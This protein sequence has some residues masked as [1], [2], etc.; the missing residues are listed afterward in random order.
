MLDG[1]LA[2]VRDEEVD[3]GVGVLLDLVVVGAA[4]LELVGVGAVVVWVT[5]LVG[6]GVE[7]TEVVA[8]WLFNGVSDSRVPAIDEGAADEADVRP[9]TVTGGRLGT[10]G[11]VVAAGL[12]AAVEAGASAC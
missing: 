6:V 3:V 7:D 2:V 5:V 4:G 10:G 12:P 1:A 9:G 8:L 11:G